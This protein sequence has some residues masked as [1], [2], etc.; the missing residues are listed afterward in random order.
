MKKYFT[1]ALLF[2]SM[3]VFTAC[4]SDDDDEE[5]VP[6][7]KAADKLVGFWFI[8]NVK[9]HTIQKAGSTLTLILFKEGKM[10]YIYPGE[11]MSDCSW[12]Y[13]EKTGILATTAQ[14]NEANLQW[15]ITLSGPQEWSGIALWS[16]DRSTHTAKPG[17]YKDVISMI[18][19]DSKWKN[20]KGETVTFKDYSGYDAYYYGTAVGKG[21]LNPHLRAY[22][23]SYNY[24]TDKLTFE[25][26]TYRLELN[27]VGVKFTIEHPYSLK[28]AK[29]IIE[30][31]RENVINNGTYTRTN[32]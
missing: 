7:S 14:I 30:G 28:E 5:S 13:N 26:Y 8:K 4:P 18:L 27:K 24:S 9:T 20:E 15:E 31:E 17:D 25:D 19:V 23:I 2:V 16:E 29:M 12:T 3:F 6:S 11:K 22:N 21:V 32:D 10:R 1:Y